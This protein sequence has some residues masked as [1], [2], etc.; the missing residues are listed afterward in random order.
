MAKRRYALAHAP[1]L[2]VVR[3]GDDDGAIRALLRPAGEARA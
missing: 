3:S 2:V 1:L